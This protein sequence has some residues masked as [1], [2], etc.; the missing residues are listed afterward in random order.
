V[1]LASL[2]PPVPEGIPVYNLPT[3][4]FPLRRA[5]VAPALVAALLAAWRLRALGAVKAG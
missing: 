1:Y 4:T 2:F 3:Y 5:L